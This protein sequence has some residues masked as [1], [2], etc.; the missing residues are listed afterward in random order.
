MTLP[1]DGSSTPVPAVSSPAAATG[2]PAVWTL[3]SEL[4]RSPRE[5]GVRD[6]YP[7]S[8]KPRKGIH[9]D[10]GTRAGG[11]SAGSALPTA[12]SGASGSTIVGADSGLAGTEE[13]QHVVA[14]LL[15]GTGSAEPS[16]ITTLLAGP[17]LRGTVVSQR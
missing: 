10:D 15:S 7:A 11:T 8:A 6:F 13:E 17:M 12:F 1:I 9:F 3:V 16:A 5:E 14:A 4:S 2:C